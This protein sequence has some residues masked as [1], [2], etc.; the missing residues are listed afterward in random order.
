MSYTI[1]K[2]E[3]ATEE[4]SREEWIYSLLDILN[5][6]TDNQ[7]KEFSFSDYEK[8]EKPKRIETAY[9]LGIIPETFDNQGNLSS[10]KRI[11]C[12]YFCSWDEV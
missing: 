12:I 3:V 4:I 1:H 8:V 9:R 11:Y 5:V 7:I 6:D 10:N 2:D